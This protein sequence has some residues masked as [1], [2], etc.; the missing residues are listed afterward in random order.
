MKPHQVRRVRL[1]H[2]HLRNWKKKKHKTEEN[3]NEK[4]G[5][6]QNEKFKENQN[7]KM[8]QRNRNNSLH[9]EIYLVPSMCQI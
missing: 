3:P 8:S 6:K 2:N 1:I 7:E 4:L 5:G 9:S